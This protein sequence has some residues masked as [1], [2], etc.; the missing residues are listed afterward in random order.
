VDLL[1]YSRAESAKSIWQEFL[2]IRAKRNL[3]VHRAETASE[4]EAGLAIS[5]ASCIV[6]ELFPSMIKKLGLYLH[7]HTVRDVAENAPAGTASG[8]TKPALS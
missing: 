7:G 3:V 1:N 4:E 6:E 5:V 2:V 8:L